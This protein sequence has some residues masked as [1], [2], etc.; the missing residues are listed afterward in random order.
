M[1]R[2]LAINPYFCL[3]VYWALLVQGCAQYASTTR[4]VDGEILVGRPIYT[5]AYAAYMTAQLSEQQGALHRAHQSYLEAARSDPASPELW[6][7]VGALSCRLKLA[8]ADRELERALKLDRWYAPAWTARARCELFRKHLDLALKFAKAGQVA[9]PDDIQTTLTL[10]EVYKARG[11]P[12]KA[13][14]QLTAYV[15]RYPGSKEA[16]IKL[17]QLS[18]EA[19][20]VSAQIPNGEGTLDQALVR[21]ILS[22]DLT[23]A[24]ERITGLGLRQS[25]LARLA[26]DFN[27]PKLAN[28]QM[29]LLLAAAPHDTELRALALLAAHRANDETTFQRWLVLPSRFTICSPQCV[30]YLDQ[31]LAEHVY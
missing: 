4:I 12:D 18:S 23:A 25:D 9:D 3:V 20:T 27:R 29:K 11:N 19:A 10:V 6:T 13:L 1:T 21:A 26:L 5:E 7:R 16:A 2:G 22:N 30:A 8:L 31:V 14:N 28:T 15:L 24:R 17:S